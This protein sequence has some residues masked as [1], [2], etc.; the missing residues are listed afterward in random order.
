M[1]E[2]IRIGTRRSALAMWQ[3]RFVSDLLEKKGMETEIIGIET[4][5][6][7]VLDVAIAKIGDKGV[8]TQELEDMLSTGDIDIAVHS[9]KDLPSE[10]P[11]GFELIAFT[12]R[13]KAQDVFVSRK[14][15]AELE[16]AE[17][18]L[19]VGSSSVRR[20]AF[21]HRYFPHLRIVDMRGNLQT[22]LG[23][24][25]AGVCDILML[26]FAGVHRMGFD[27]LIV[28]ELSIDQIVPPVGQGTL[29]VESSIHLDPARKR[30]IREGV[31][32]PET[33][34]VILAERAFLKT[35]RGGCSIPVF[36]HAVMEN[37]RV[38]LTGGLISLD[39]KKLIRECR[40]AMPEMSFELG[41]SVAEKVLERGGRLLLEEIRSKQ[42]ENAR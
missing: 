26:A 9:A 40:D 11:S 25:Q 36:A 17:A 33:E 22:R 34:K 8:F 31:N 30:R 5:G 20:T 35:L 21:L 42:K 39:G 37:G 1:S 2:K 38:F 24:M 14:S 10:L 7:R 32:H 4:Q 3:A 12:R 6:D 27:H 41:E 18:G 29:A 13:E 16:N 23:K 15:L 28:K 19:R